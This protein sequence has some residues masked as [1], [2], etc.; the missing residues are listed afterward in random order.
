MIEYKVKYIIAKKAGIKSNQ[1]HDDD[2][3]LKSFGFDSLDY[4]MLLLEIEKEFNTELD[5]EKMLEHTTVRDV[6]DEI[7]SKK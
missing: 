6:I 7:R 5:V 4:A 2:L 3:I 1:V